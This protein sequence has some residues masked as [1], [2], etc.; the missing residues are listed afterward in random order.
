MKKN[1][2]VV[3]DDLVN[4]KLA[5]VMLERDG[6]TVNEC[7][8]GITALKL[9]SQGDFSAVLLDISL[10]GK[11][12]EEVCAQLR[13]RGTDVFIVAYTAHTSQQDID[14]MLASGFDRVLLKP[15]TFDA[16]REVFGTLE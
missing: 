8:D 7:A 4:C 16:M 15:V 10:P 3:D 11:S 5:R 9:A 6:W 2:L 14:R 12:G 1:V 13:Q